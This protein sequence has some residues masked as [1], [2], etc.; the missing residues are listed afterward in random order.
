MTTYFYNFPRPTEPD[1]SPA[2]CKARLWPK[3]RALF[4]QHYIDHQIANA[5][6]EARSTSKE[7][8]HELP[9]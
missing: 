7:L 1:A 6:Q 3:E 8:N 4:M 5:P 9:V 2:A